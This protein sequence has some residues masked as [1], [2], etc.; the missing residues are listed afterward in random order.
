[1]TTIIVLFNLRPDIKVADYEKFARQID[2][3]AVNRLPSVNSFEV[4]RTVGLMDGSP[5]PY[6]YIEVLRIESIDALGKDVS[7]P[8][9]Q[10]VVETFRAMADNPLF[11]VTE[12]L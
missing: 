5:A 9:M 6:Q 2:L 1:M 12:A 3:P 4:L 8:A 10:K 11:I 7:V